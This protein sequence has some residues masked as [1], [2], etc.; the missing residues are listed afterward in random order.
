M[1]DRRATINAGV[2]WDWF[3]SATDPES[4]PAGTFNP[5]VT[6][7]DCSDGHN[8]LNAGCTGRVTNWKDFSPRVGV[9]FDLFGN[10]KTAVKASVA[11]YVNGVGLA[12]GS[13]TDNNNPETTRRPDRHARVA[14][15][16]RQRLAVHVDRRDS[17]QRADQLDLD[18]ELRQERALVDD[19][20]I[21]RCSKA[22]ARAATTGSTPSAASTSWR[23]AC[24]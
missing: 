3:I 5:A 1:D 9:A 10:G 6:Y 13:I 17:A 22:G 8:N 18:A 23:R 7:G 19:R 21:R 4:L 2:R 11:R 14:R 20:P 24:R 12:A 15:P 16:R